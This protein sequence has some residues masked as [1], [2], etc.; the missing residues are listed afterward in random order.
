MRYSTLTRRYFETAASAGTLDGAGVRRGEAGSRAGG[1]WVRFD[2]R[3]AP[4][5]GLIEEAR[6]LAHG[7]PHT[8]AVAAWVAEQAAGGPARAQLPEDVQSLRR[9]FEVPVEKL[10]RLLVVEDAWCAALSAAPA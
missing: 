4:G 3:V 6:F 7:C 2:V 10:G 1:V 5:T 8:L 9:R